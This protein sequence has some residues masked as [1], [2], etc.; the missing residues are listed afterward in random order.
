MRLRQIVAEALGVFTSSEEAPKYNPLSVPSTFTSIKSASGIY[1]GK[2]V[3]MVSRF[4]PS[5]ACPNGQRWN[6]YRC[7][8]P[9]HQRDPRNQTS[10]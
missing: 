2:G 9:I 10:S 4:P 7:V 5:R 3:N 8:T 6:G 1:G